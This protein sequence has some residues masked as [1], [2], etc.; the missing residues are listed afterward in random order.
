M[1]KLLFDAMVKTGTYKDRNGQ[2]K[3]R[4]LK[5][6]SVFEGEKGMSMILDCV[7]VGIPAPVWVKFFQPKEKQ[8]QQQDNA[9]DDG[10]GVP[11]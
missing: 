8:Q 6:G 10:N 4:W 11:F 9:P 5:I 2:E 1:S 3:G 7:P